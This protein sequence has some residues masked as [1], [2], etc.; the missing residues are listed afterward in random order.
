M[1]VWLCGFSECCASILGHSLE[2]LLTLSLRLAE[3]LYLWAPPAPP[4]PALS[5]PLRSQ[6]LQHHGTLVRTGLWDQTLCPGHSPRVSVC[7]RVCT[8]MPSACPSTSGS[9]LSP[10]R[11][12]WTRLTPCVTLETPRGRRPS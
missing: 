11:H 3:Q 6:C 10:S 4:Q 2:V 9:Q 5:S 12:L 1:L 8:P 7:A